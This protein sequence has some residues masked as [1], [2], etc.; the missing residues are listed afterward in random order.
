M[1][2]FNDRLKEKRAEMVWQASDDLGYS[3]DKHT[4]RRK[5]NIRKARDT[6]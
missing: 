4:E 3:F 6:E 2:D 1:T 5:K